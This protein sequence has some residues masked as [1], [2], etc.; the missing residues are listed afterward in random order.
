LGG[1]NA[2]A[3]PAALP[4]P[5]ALPYDLTVYLQAYVLTGG[6]WAS[7]NGVAFTTAQL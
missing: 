1:P 5:G 6:G 7:S 4:A 3:L 2:L